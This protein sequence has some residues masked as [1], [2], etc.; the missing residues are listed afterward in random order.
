MTVTLTR[1][2]AQQQKA[3]RLADELINT[4]FRITRYEAAAELRRLHKSEREGWRY[5]DELEQE[6]KR[7][8][9]VNAELVDALDCLMKWQVKNVQVW[10]NSAYD[11]AHIA[12][13]KATG[14][15]Q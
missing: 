15:E 5:A 12:I 7:L 2:E 1:E 9:E 3:I 6:R 4:P 11:N 10:N 14:E 8:H 13:T